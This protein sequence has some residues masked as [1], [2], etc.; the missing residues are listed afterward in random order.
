[1][2]ELSIATNI[3]DAAEDE[4]RKLGYNSISL[5]SLE[6]G[7][8]ASIEPN[9]LSFCF[10]AASKN[11]IAKNA[12]LDIN[13]VPGHGICNTCHNQIEVK[14]IPCS[15]PKC[16]KFSLTIKDGFQIL[17]KNMEVNNV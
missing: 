15:C 4:A 10:E 7:S 5:I 17:I 14:T 13:L 1:M 2:H 12:I 6:I 16:N 3:L 8:L 9:S 11:T